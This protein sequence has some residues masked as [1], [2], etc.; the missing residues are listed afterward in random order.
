MI[1]VLIISYIVL[2]E[3]HHACSFNQLNILDATLA[4][5][6]NNMVVFMLLDI[7]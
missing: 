3:E 7:S 4:S 2:V 6:T 1:F 5:F